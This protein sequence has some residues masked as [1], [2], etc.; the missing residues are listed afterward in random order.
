[1]SRGQF[2]TELVLRCL[3]M[4]LWI[5]EAPTV[6]VEHRAPRNLMFRKIVQNIWDQF[7][8]YRVIARIPFA[9]TVKYH[10][11]ARVDLDLRHAA[12]PA[13]IE[14]AGA[15]SSKSRTLEKSAIR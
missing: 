13:G 12:L 2:D 8:L 14:R 10:R 15:N 7:R 3:R 11:Y 9:G 4:G 6:Y 5:A 1:M